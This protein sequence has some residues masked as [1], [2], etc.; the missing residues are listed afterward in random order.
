MS[1]ELHRTSDTNID[2][3]DPDGN[4]VTSYDPPV[5]APNDVLPDILDDLGISDTSIRSAVKIA[6][7][8]MVEYKDMR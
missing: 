7:T 6:A 4:V 1:Y 5:E 2:L 3:V 8:G